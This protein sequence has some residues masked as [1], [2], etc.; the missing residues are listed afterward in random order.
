MGNF[1]ISQSQKIKHPFIHNI[2][3][4]KQYE[5]FTTNAFQNIGGPENALILDSKPKPGAK[6]I[7]MK[8]KMKQ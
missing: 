7:F 8:S 5:S 4:K 1:Y 3:H 2:L 6:N